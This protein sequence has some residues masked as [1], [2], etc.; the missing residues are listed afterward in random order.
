M[1]YPN[2]NCG[3]CPAWLGMSPLDFPINPTINN[4]CITCK[5]FTEQKFVKHIPTQCCYPL[6]D[7]G[8]TVI[9]CG[10]K[11]TP[12]IDGKIFWKY[13]DKYERKVFT[14]SDPYANY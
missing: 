12:E 9:I 8:K 14:P 10:A 6:E 7:D 3:E 11:L 1:S 5:L 13:V 4:V 2:N